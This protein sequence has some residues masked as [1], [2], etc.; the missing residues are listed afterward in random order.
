ML[1]SE[2]RT[3]YPY[4]HVFCPMLIA[5]RA[6]SNNSINLSSFDEVLDL[7]G[8]V[9]RV[10]LLAMNLATTAKLATSISLSGLTFLASRHREPHCP[11]VGIWLGSLA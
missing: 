9:D 6:L 2:T 10:R 11:G 5:P 1:T 8:P 4:I 3:E 7:F